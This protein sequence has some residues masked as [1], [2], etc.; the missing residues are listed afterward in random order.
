MILKSLGPLLLVS[1]GV[2]VRRRVSLTERKKILARREID[3][4]MIKRFTSPNAVRVV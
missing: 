1:G 2:K 3:R 4:I